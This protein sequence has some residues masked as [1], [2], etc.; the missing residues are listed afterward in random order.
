MIR[1]SLESI[2]LHSLVDHSR[3]S[4]SSNNTKQQYTTQPSVF[5]RQIVITVGLIIILLILLLIY[6]FA[7]VNLASIFINIIRIEKYRILPICSDLVCSRIPDEVN[8]LC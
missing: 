7:F 4:F 6:G 2:D 5:P 1:E 3:S 8:C